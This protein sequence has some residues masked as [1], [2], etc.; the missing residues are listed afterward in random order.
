MSSSEEEVFLAAPEQSGAFAQRQ[1]ATSH[2]G[3]T[4]GPAISTSDMRT[5][6]ESPNRENCR[7]GDETD[8]NMQTLLDWKKQQLYIALVNGL[9]INAVS[10]YELHDRGITYSRLAQTLTA[11]PPAGDQ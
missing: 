7:D 3:A 5:F 6:S 9:V 4:D 2:A 8:Y 10:R 1:N 11:F